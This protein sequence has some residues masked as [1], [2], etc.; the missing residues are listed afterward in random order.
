MDQNQ[1]LYAKDTTTRLIELFQETF[2][3]YFKS[4]WEATPTSIPPISDFP[5][6][7]VQ[8]L[9]GKS[10][11]GATSTDNL[12]ETMSI[13]V[14]LNRADDV[15]SSNIRTTTMR[16]LE[17][18]VEGLDP[19]TYDYLPATF[20]YAVRKHLT[21]IG[22]DGMS[23]IIDSDVT[24]DYKQVPQKEL[25]TMCIADLTMTTVRRVIVP[26]RS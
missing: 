15:G 11:I 16:K 18:L 1:Q 21:M 10:M 6:V 23:Y 22:N 3:D 26:G 14:M 13:A 4:Y 24:Y 25:P 19:V 9:K 17:N 5:L 7:I 20:L 8:K 12:T 2:G